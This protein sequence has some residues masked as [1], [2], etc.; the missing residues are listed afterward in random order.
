MFFIPAGKTVS[1]GSGLSPDCFRCRCPRRLNPQ[2]RGASPPS[3]VR[4]RRKDLPQSLH[5][6][7]CQAPV[8]H[9]NVRSDHQSCRDLC[10]SCK[11]QTRFLT[12]LR[13][14]FSTSQMTRRVRSSLPAAS[15]TVNVQSGCSGRCVAEL[16]PGISPVWIGR[17]DV[18]EPVPHAVRPGRL[19]GVLPS[20]RAHQQAGALSVQER[21]AQ[22]AAPKHLV[23]V[24]V[25]LIQ[26][27][28]KQY[29]KPSRARM[30]N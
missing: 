20:G 26:Y 23:M 12:N 27:S 13:L 5:G 24:Q 3:L 2:V 1:N 22:V 18:R 19:P 16:L 14:L 28:L 9:P 25:Y 29:L 30:C 4:H 21:D 15:R 11:P 17:T 7:L 10:S 8:S 6:P